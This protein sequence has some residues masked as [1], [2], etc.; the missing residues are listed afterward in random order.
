M[1]RSH[2]GGRRQHPRAP[3]PTAGGTPRT[4]TSSGSFGRSPHTCAAAPTRAL[5]LG[6]G[7]TARSAVLALAELGVTTLTVRARDTGRAADLLAWALDLGAGIRNGSVAALGPWVTTR[8]DVV[9]STLPGSAGEVAAATVPAGAPRRPARRRLRRVAD[10]ARPRGGC[11]RHDRGA[12]ARHARAPGGGAVPAVHRSRGPGRGDGRRG[13]RRPGAGS[14]P[15]LGGARRGRRAWGWWG[16]SPGAGSRPVATA[17]PRTR[18]TTRRVATGGRGSPRPLS[19]PW[20]R[21]SV[22]D[23]GGWAALP[24]YLLFAWLTVGLVWID[25]DVHRL[26]VGPG[27][28]RPVRGWLALLAVASVAD[29]DRRWRGRARRGGGHG[30]GLPAARRAARAAAWAAA[31]CGSRRSSGR[32]SGG[33]GRA[34]RGGTARRVPRRRAGR[35]GAA[36]CCGR[37]GLRSSIAYGPAMCLGAWVAI[38]VHVPDPDLARGR[39]RAAWKDSPHAALADRRGVARARAR[40][41]DRRAARRGRGHHRRRRRRAGAPAAGLRPRVPG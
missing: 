23:L 12:R 38:A 16:T 39:L 8:D 14:D 4:P 3:R 2:A 17:S 32:C 27:R 25:L 6:A 18:S 26:P 5:V 11:R 29:R 36:R 40:R 31:T 7:A 10:P 1:P 33:S 20:R 28:A 9:V 24:A 37:V 41:D 35:R 21:W 22:G 34:G 30:G 15:G 19:P 13:A